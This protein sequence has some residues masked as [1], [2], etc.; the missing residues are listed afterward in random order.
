MEY[1]GAWYHVMNRG[2]RH[3]DIF[4]E[5]KDYELFVDLLK[6]SSDTWGI[7]VSAYCL[8]SNHYHMLIQTP[9]GNLARAMRHLDGVYTQ[10]YNR[11]HSVDG[12]LFRGRYKSILVN[13]D[14]YLLQLVRYIHRNPL[15]AGL[16]DTLSAYAWSSHKGYLSTA[17][18]WDWLHKDFIYALLSEK[19]MEWIKRYRQ[20]ISI[21]EDDEAADVLES[22]KWPSV[23]GPKAFV[24]WVKANFY[25]TKVDDEIPQSKY[26]TPSFEDIIKVLSPVKNGPI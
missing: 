16:V 20:F 2:G 12:Q 6:E 19:K 4:S 11:R 21:E 23:W 22:R 1:E 10:R 7:N 5:P 18:K 9:L 8:M 26:L 24:D 3:G 17:S 13:G 15:K 14:S 25:E